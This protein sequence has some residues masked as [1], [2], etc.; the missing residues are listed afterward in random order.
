[1]CNARIRSCPFF[2]ICNYPNASTLAQTER[3]VTNAHE[4]PLCTTITARQ[5]RALSK[6]TSNHS[7]RSPP[8]AQSPKNQTQSFYIRSTTRINLWYTAVYCEHDV[9]MSRSKPL[10]RGHWALICTGI[11]LIDDFKRS[12]PRSR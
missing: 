12:L 6:L 9:F 8:I 11:Q 2:S 5:P 10:S 7:Y 4:R 3:A 1:M